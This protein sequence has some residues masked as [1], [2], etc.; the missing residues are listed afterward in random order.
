M[1]ELPFRIPMNVVSYRRVKASTAYLFL[2][3]PLHAHCRCIL[4][5][6]LN[7]LEQFLCINNATNTLKF[8]TPTTKKLC[9]VTSAHPDIMG[10]LK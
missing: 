8:R 3:E 1:M 4:L 5:L 7:V 2:A 10:S 6:D 9:V